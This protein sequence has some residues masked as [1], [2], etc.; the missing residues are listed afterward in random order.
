MNLNINVNPKE[1]G[2]MEVHAERKREERKS[3][4][5][6]HTQRERGE[7]GIHKGEEREKERTLAYQFYYVK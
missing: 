2:G 4:E 1:K 3:Q 5:R 7:G 6:G